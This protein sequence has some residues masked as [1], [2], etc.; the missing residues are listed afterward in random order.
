MYLGEQ[1]Q[2]IRQVDKNIFIESY[3]STHYVHATLGE[4]LSAQY[5][6][7][8]YA[9][10]HLC[11]KFASTVQVVTTFD[12]LDTA[13]LLHHN[14]VFSILGSVSIIIFPTRRCF[15]LRPVPRQRCVPLLEF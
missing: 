13:S 11:G 4:G 15:G 12:D 2:C 10:K 1:R 8:A 5:G 6:V 7:Q 14:H 3:T 9:H